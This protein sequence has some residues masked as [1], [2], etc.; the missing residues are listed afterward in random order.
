MKVFLGNK[1]S[2]PANNASEFD[3]TCEF[4]RCNELGPY[5]APKTPINIRSYRWFCLK[6]VRDYNKAWNFFEGWTRKDIEQI[7]GF[8]PKKIDI[9]R[10]AFVHK[11]ILRIIKLLPKDSVPDYM[12][13][14]NERLEF[15]GDAVLSNITAFY[16]YN[17]FPDKDEGFLTKKRSKL[18]DTKALSNYARKKDLGK[19]MLMSRHL[20][21]MDG[22]NREKM[23]ENVMEALIGAIYID[24]GI[25]HVTTFVHNLFDNLTDWNEVL[26]DTNFKD[27]I[28]R[29]CQTNALELPTYEI[30][31]TDG[32]PHDRTFEMIVQH[33][34]MGLLSASSSDGRLTASVSV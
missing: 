4:P 23:L 7:I 26:R 30:N 20:V 28:L 5:R 9:F 25:E 19:H 12:Y 27:Q 17:K 6:H 31:K 16:L 21:Q 8:R 10:Q 15:V 13:E 24:L 14:S 22:K 32:P 1:R 2:S 11:S 3:H 18:V 29:Y 33:T 34:T